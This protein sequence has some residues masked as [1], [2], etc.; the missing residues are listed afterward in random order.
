M[1]SRLTSASRTLASDPEGLLSARLERA[2]GVAVLGYALIR[3]AFVGIAL[4]D[5]GVS[6]RVFAVI[7]LSTAYPYG[8]AMSRLASALASG[9]YV[10][11]RRPA[12]AALVLFVAPY[13]YVLLAARQAPPGIVGGVAAFAVVSSASAMVGVVRRSPARREAS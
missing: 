13:A 2:V 9:Q 6:V 12:F 4:S 3:I 1:H 5:Y 10:Q 7:E 8:V 11:A